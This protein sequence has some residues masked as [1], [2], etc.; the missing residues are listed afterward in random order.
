MSVCTLW[1]DRWGSYDLTAACQV[2][3]DDYATQAGFITSNVR[4][5]HNASN[6]FHPAMGTVMLIGTT[7]FGWPWYLAAKIKLWW[8]MRQPTAAALVVIGAVFS[9]SFAIGYFGAMLLDFVRGV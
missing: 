3:D 1:P 8:K 9:I 4:L 7:L 2:H 5:Y 6:A